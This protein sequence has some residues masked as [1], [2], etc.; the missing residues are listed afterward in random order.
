MFSVKVVLA[1]GPRPSCL[2]G[3]P[4]GHGHCFGTTSFSV[5]FRVGAAQ[6]PARSNQR[7]RPQKETALHLAARLASLSPLSC[8]PPER[9]APRPAVLAPL[10]AAGSL[11][12]AAAP[13]PRV[14][15]LRVGNAPL[16]AALVQPRRASGLCWSHAVE[17]GTKS[18]IAALSVLERAVFLISEAEVTCD[19]DGIDSLLDR[20]DPDVVRE[21]ANAF[22]SIGA[23]KIAAALTDVA[24]ALPNRIDGALDLAND[25]I[26]S[27]SGYDFESVCRFIHRELSGSG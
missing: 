25:L 22:R 6:D 2:S 19:K 14:P 24:S 18:G 16:F 3:G 23:S 7:V 21:T 1:V 10:R 8:S 26:C 20:Y 27:R 17:R 15:T 4:S 9:V 5:R 12:S 11:L 13:R